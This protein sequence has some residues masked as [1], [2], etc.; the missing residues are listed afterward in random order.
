MTI[1]KPFLSKLQHFQHFLHASQLVLLCLFPA[2]WAADACRAARLLFARLQFHCLTVKCWD[3]SCAQLVDCNFL[4]QRQCSRSKLLS[5]MSTSLQV[6]L[7]VEE[8]FTSF[9]KAFM[10]FSRHNNQEHD[11]HLCR[12]T[13]FKISTQRKNVYRCLQLKAPTWNDSNDKLQ[14]LKSKE[15]KICAQEKAWKFALL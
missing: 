14:P 12:S 13:K 15:N 6:L 11:A 3:R 5:A 4:L 1:H 2:S 10:L 9:Q 8:N 7:K